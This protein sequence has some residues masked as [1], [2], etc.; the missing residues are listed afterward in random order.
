MLSEEDRANFLAR[1]REPKHLDEDRVE[2]SLRSLLQHVKTCDREVRRVTLALLECPR[3]VED[4]CGGEFRSIK[5]DKT[6]DHSLR[7][8]VREMNTRSPQ[9]SRQGT[10]MA[11]AS[12]VAKSYSPINFTESEHWGIKKADDVLWRMMGLSLGARWDLSAHGSKQLSTRA[13]LDAFLGGA[14]LLRWTEKCLYWLAWP[15]VAAE[16]DARTE[17]RE[18]GPEIRLHSETGPVIRTDI[19][20][21]YF[22]DGVTVDEITA[23]RPQELTVELVTSYTN[24]EHRRVAMERFPGGMEQFLSQSGAELVDHRRNERDAQLESLYRS[25]HGT[26]LACSD[27]STGRRYTLPVPPG[28]GTCQAAQDWISHGLDRRA[29]H[30]S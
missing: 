24:A 8:L 1:C 27:P 26:F 21:C 18:R 10:A 23:R 30:R 11:V 2:T 7:D 29:V 19:G 14:W 3:A 5:S 12:A 16:Y 20:D 9:V 13:L 25:S 6:R 28:T 4:I 22:I 17:L 15:R